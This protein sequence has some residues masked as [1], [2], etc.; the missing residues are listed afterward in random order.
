MEIDELASIDDN[1]LE[2]LSELKPS[3]VVMH[4]LGRARAPLLQPHRRMQWSTKYM[5]EWI[6]SHSEEEAMES[7]NECL[8]AYEKV[9]ESRATQIMRFLCASLTL[10]AAT[11]SMEKQFMKSDESQNAEDMVPEYKLLKVLG[12][13]LLQRY[14][15]RA[16]LSTA[17]PAVVP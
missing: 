16:G 11:F 7:A 10:T 2:M 12:P 5:V 14:K 6:D 13:K 8:V 9:G 15:R 17:K 1:L 4:I 3:C